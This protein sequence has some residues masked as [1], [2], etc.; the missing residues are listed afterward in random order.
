MKRPQKNLLVDSCCCLQESWRAGSNW[1]AGPSHPDL[2]NTTILTQADVENWMKELSNWG[3]WGKEDQ[4]GA[5]NSDHSSKEEG[6][7]ATGCGR[8][9]GVSGPRYRKGKSDRQS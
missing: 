2:G 3:R 1:P 8:S 4:L 7:G 6:G 9:F 5:V